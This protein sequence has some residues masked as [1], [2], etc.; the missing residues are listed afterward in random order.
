MQDRADRRVHVGASEVRDGRR[1]LKPN[2]ARRFDF[3]QFVQGFSI[4]GF[5]GVP[6]GGAVGGE[7]FAMVMAATGFAAAQQPYRESQH[8]AAPRGNYGRSTLWPPPHSSV[9]YSERWYADHGNALPFPCRDPVDSARP[10]EVA[11][12][13]REGII[14]GRGRTW[15][16]FTEEKCTPAVNNVR[17]AAEEHSVGR[18]CSIA[19]RLLS[20]RSAR[21]F[22]SAAW[23]TSLAAGSCKMISFFPVSMRAGLS[24]TLPIR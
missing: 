8:S 22:V 2:L 14:R 7:L 1:S 10:F 16:R 15:T 24:T 3:H 6:G 18:F 17:V 19:S 9:R 21:L 5:L 11:M 23:R 13:K 12:P 20:A 4:S